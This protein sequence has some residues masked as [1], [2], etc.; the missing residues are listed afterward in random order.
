[1]N[2]QYYDQVDL[3]ITVLPALREIKDFALKGGTAINL[4]FRDMP[5]L[6]VDIDL[7]FI[8]LLDRDQSSRVIDSN[9]RIFASK[10]MNENSS[11]RAITK[12]SK[13]GYIKNLI[14]KNSKAQIKIEVNDI[15]RGFVYPCETK[16]LCTKAQDEFLKYTEIQ[17]LSFFD[18]YAGKIC[19]ALDRQHPRDLFDI[20][21]L[22][23][24]EG[25]SDKLKKTFILSILVKYFIM[26][27]Y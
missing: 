18:L 25:F 13:D 3:L 1:M 9:L 8:R 14:V 7:A 6:S 23:E 16:E 22:L 24:T 15:I 21:L 11:I 10:I 20:K 17:T 19:A 26:F 5:R 27:F 2:K 4:F 12:N